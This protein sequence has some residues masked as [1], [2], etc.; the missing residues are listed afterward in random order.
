MNRAVSLDLLRGLSIFGMLF[1]ATIP[2][3]DV[4]PSWMYH[5]QCP[6]PTHAFNP[7][8]PGIT[9]VDLVLPVFIFCMGAAIPLALVRKLEKGQSYGAISQQ[10]IVRFFVLVFFAIYIAHIVPQAIGA[11]KLELSLLG[12]EI[13]DY[14]VQLLTLVGFMLMFPMFAVVRDAK[15]RLIYRVV[16][17]GG[18]LLLLMVLHFAYGQQFSVWRSN[19]IILLLADVYLLGAFGWLLT[20]SSMTA[21]LMLF[22]LFAALQLVCKYTGFA[23]IADSYPCI[24]WFFK[25]S[26]SYYLLLLIPATIAGDLIAKRLKDPVSFQQQIRDSRCKHIFFWGLLILSAWIVVALFSR[27]LM[28]NAMVCS[29]VLGGLCVIVR[30]HL[31][32]YSKMLTLSICLLAIGFLIE[33]VEG[34]IK[35]DPVTASY[36]LITAGISLNLLMF[37]DYVVACFASNK[38]LKIMEGAG[39]NPLMAYVMTSWFAF[40]LLKLTFLIEI[41]AQL[42]PEGYPWLGVLRSVALVV[43]LMSLVRFMMKRKIIWRV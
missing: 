29:A 24:S 4:L 28:L 41:Y 36:L 5:A 31:P 7:N 12:V 38:L 8:I 30:K 2:F 22:I 21:R 17:W 40:P 16:G 10:I 13:K 25:L 18:S 11:G 42:Y 27:W 33:P 15:K 39:A 14:D 35:K 3:G 32:T 1:S 26:M 37:L 9:W 23:H 20:R 6:P 43:S 34:G 19:V